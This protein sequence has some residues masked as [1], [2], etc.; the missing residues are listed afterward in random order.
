MLFYPPVI[1][2]WWCSSDGSEAWLL[3]AAGPMAWPLV[4][5]VPNSSFKQT[6]EWFMRTNML[7]S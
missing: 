7:I 3:P 5:N 1:I 6:F 2:R 4:S